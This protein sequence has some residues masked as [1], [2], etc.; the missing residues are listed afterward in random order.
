MNQILVVEDEVVIRA[1]L[2]RLLER[3]EYRVCEAGSVKESLEK[4]DVD[5]FDVIISDLRL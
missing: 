4:Y 1:A 5:S 3:H 2:R